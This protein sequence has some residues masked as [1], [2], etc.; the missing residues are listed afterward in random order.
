MAMRDLHCCTAASCVAQM[1][2]YDDV[3]RGRRRDDQRKYDMFSTVLDNARH[4]WAQRT[5]YQRMIREINELSNR[6]L[7]DMKADRGSM[8]RHA[9]AEVYG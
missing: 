6:D 1:A 7:A 4:R 5:R 8:I 9:Y 2:G 3:H